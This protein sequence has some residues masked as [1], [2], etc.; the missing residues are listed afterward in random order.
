MILSATSPRTTGHDDL[1][2]GSFLAYK[3]KEKRC[4]DHTAFPK[5]VPLLLYKPSVKHDR[6]SHCRDLKGRRPPIIRWLESPA[7]YKRIATHYYTRFSIKFY[8]A[9]VDNIIP[10]YKYNLNC[11]SCGP[12]SH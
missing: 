10:K 5:V 1:D 4:F 6:A 11:S 7:I 3:P 12:G 2:L 8:V 9:S